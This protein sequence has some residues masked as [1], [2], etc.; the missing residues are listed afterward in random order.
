M[1][2]KR[3]TAPEI[4]G[5]VATPVTVFHSWNA[6]SQTWQYHH[7]SDYRPDARKVCVSQAL[8]TGKTSIWRFMDDESCLVLYDPSD[9]DIARVV[10]EMADGHVVDMSSDEESLQ[11]RTVSKRLLDAGFRYDEYLGGNA[12]T[13]TDGRYITAILGLDSH[14]KQEVGYDVD[15]VVYP[16][17]DLPNAVIIA[18]HLNDAFPV[19]GHETVVPDLEAGLEL[20]RNQALP[21]PNIADHGWDE[22]DIDR[23]DRQYAAPGGMEAYESLVDSIKYR[24]VNFDYETLVRGSSPTA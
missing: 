4:E 1:D 10:K 15:S 11:D 23:I 6:F 17:I 24:Q 2:R 13:M 20:V 21:R 9:A 18:W 19:V 8:D 5:Y 16:S 12:W 14:M 7:P 3:E 22:S